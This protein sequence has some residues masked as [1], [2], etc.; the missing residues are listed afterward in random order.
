M[1]TVIDV[2]DELMT[3]LVHSVGGK[4]VC[5][6]WGTLIGD[7]D[8][9]VCQGK[10]SEKTEIGRAALLCTV[11][12]STFPLD[13]RSRA[14]TGRGTGCRLGRT[15]SKE[16]AKSVCHH[17]QAFEETKPE[18]WKESVDAAKGKSEISRSSRR[19]QKNPQSAANEVPANSKGGTRVDASENARHMENRHCWT[20][21]LQ[22]SG[23][24]CSESDA[25]AGPLL[26]DAMHAGTVK[27]MHEVISKL[28][29]R[30]C[31]IQRLDIV[32]Q[33]FASKTLPAEGDNLF[34]SLHGRSTVWKHPGGMKWKLFLV[35]RGEWPCHRSFGVL[36]AWSRSAENGGWVQE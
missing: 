26:D 24:S 25:W 3:G 30:N 8:F 34:W 35:P 27:D 33:A 12:R 31:G 28:L 29:V 23:K 6:L 21:T 2:E 13:K 19:F 4:Y 10:L 7:K 18:I 32:I 1:K 36:V 22:G 9:R 17:G 5:A 15:P 14:R 11:T 20:S 16:R